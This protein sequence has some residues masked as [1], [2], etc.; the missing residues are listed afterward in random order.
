MPKN[1]MVIK[2]WL[3]LPFL[4]IGLKFLFLASNIGETWTLRK[5]DEFLF[6]K[7]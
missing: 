2:D 3:A 5:L 6:R 1:K 7:Q 4:R